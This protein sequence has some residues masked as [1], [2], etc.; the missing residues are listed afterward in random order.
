[1][2]RKYRNWSEDDMEKA[3]KLVRS[4]Y[5]KSEASHQCSVPRSTL[6]DRL[7]GKKTENQRKKT[8]LSTNDE[9]E[10][11]NYVMFMSDS[12]APVTPKWIRETAGRLGAER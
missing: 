11:A 2:P 12:G 8:K 1:M 6:R 10:L 7:N 4:G 3:V 9:K 5:S